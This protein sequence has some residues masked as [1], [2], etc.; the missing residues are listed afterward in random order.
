[1]LMPRWASRINLL[2]TADM[3]YESLLDITW[4]DSVAEGVPDIAEYLKL[5]N[6]LHPNNQF[7][8]NPYVTVTE[9]KLI[10]GN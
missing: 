10:K 4:E 8:T 5:W 3:R 7:S 2:V 6:S 9:F 1:M